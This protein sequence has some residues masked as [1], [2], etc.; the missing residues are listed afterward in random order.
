MDANGD[1]LALGFPILEHIIKAYFR[2]FS[3]CSTCL[4][5]P[6]GVD[7]R[8]GWLIHRGPTSNGHTVPAARLNLSEATDLDPAEERPGPTRPR[9]GKPPKSSCVPWTLALGCTGIVSLTPEL[10]PCAPVAE[11]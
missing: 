6:S 8:A 5:T 4:A 10:M 3:N 9:C 11:Y 7:E 2:A 1:F